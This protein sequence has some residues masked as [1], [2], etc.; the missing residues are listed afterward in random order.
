MGA[1]HRTQT[2]LFHEPPLPYNVVSPALSLQVRA[3]RGRMHIITEDRMVSRIRTIWLTVFF[4][5]TLTPG[6]ASPAAP[7]LGKDRPAAP[8]EP[9][10]PLGSDRPEDRGFVLSGGNSLHGRYSG[11]GYRFPDGSRFDLEQG[12]SGPLSL[13]Y[14]RFLSETEDT[15]CSVLIGTGIAGVYE[16]YLG[17]GVAIELTGGVVGVGRPT[18]RTNLVCYPWEGLRFSLSLDLRDGLTFGWQE[19]Q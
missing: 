9:D 5:L 1:R 19:D 3:S 6:V 15:R 13:W 8:V 7:P 10:F 18:A 16:L 4:A 2:V 12:L 11:I 14:S 17:H